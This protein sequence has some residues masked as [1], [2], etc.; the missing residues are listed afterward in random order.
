MYSEIDFREFRAGSQLD[1]AMR[2]EGF[3][4]KV[5]FDPETGFL[6]GGN[7]W[8]CGTWM[9]KMGDS[10]KAGTFGVPARR[11]HWFIKI[12]CSMDERTIEA[13]LVSERGFQTRSAQ[14]FIIF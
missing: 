6:M 14:T 8:N 7:K 2:E 5:Y 4:V 10:S 3:N 12:S 13:K 9:D 1:H 11:N